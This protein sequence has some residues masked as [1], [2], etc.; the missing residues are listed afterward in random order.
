MDYSTTAG[1]AG[2]L[3]AG[4]MMFIGVFFIIFLV[5]GLLRLIGEWKMLTKAGE[6]GWKSLIPFYNQW[7]LC[8]ISGLSPYWVLELIIVSF[9]IG[10]IDGLIGNEAISGVLS[11][12]T[13]ANTIYFGV[14]LAISLAKSFGKDTGFGVATFFFSFVTYPM[15]GM[16]SATYVGPT[17]VNDPVMKFI[18]DTLNIKDDGTGKNQNS[19]QVN[20]TNMNMN[21]QQQ[22]EQQAPQQ[23]NFN[24]QMNN[25][26]MQQANFQQETNQVNV[27]PQQVQQTEILDTPQQNSFCPNC[28][29]KVSQGDMFCQNCGTKV[30]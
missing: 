7:T 3:I 10:V 2:G 12:V 19:G 30:N 22:S 5:I 11:L 6:S 24:Q 9:V 21:T 14:I 13:S 28:G 16:G 8:K 23:P 20:Q 1:V 4:I 25:K 17:P 18:L 27:Q 26:N 29:G 15:M